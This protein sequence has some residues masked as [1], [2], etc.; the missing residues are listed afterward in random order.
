M[1]SLRS[2]TAE[3]LNLAVRVL[4][5][6]SLLHDAQAD[7]VMNKTLYHAVPRGEEHDKFKKCWFGISQDP[8]MDEHRRFPELA[9]SPIP[10]TCCA[11]SKENPV[12]WP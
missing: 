4:C 5:R 11:V 6:D 10:G 9:C 7:H 1:D 8:T 12:G 2:T 3:C